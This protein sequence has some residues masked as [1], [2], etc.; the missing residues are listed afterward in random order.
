[1][2]IRSSWV[3]EICYEDSENGG[4]TSNIPFI[5]VP[6]EEDMPRILFM[7]ESRE[8]GEFEPGA[9]GEMLPIIDLDLHQYANMATLKANLDPATLDIVREALGLEKMRSA[10][11]KGQ[12]ISNNIRKNLGQ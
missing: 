3:P 7:F 5:N 9:D 4:L 6:A 10:V 8:T 1:M 12:D 11:A 2:S